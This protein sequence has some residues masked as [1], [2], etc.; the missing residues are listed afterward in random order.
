MKKNLIFVLLIF[1]SQYTSIKAQNT[2]LT[3]YLQMP[4]KERTTDSVF[5]WVDTCKKVILNE[6]EYQYKTNSECDM[7]E[8]ALS[9]DTMKVLAGQPNAF[10]LLVEEIERKDNDSLSFDLRIEERPNPR[11][12]PSSTEIMGVIVANDTMYLGSGIMDKPQRVK[13]FY[14]TYP[15]LGT[16]EGEHLSAKYIVKNPNANHFKVKIKYYKD[17]PCFIYDYRFAIS[18]SS[19][20]VSLYYLQNGSNLIRYSTAIDGT[21]KVIHYIK[22]P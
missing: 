2:C 9:G 10:I 5:C 13:H 18:T 22:T 20:L 12:V 21:K 19:S 6:Y 8:Y 3:R 17:Y 1:I 7:K 4:L 16:D 15:Y 11:A 14:Y